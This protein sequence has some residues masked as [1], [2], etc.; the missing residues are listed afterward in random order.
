M[1]PSSH[2]NGIG[3]DSRHIRMKGMKV[4][5]QNIVTRTQEGLTK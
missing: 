5:K 1:R 2:Y 4:M 3:R